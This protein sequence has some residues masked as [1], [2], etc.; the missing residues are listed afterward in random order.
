MNNRHR[1]IKKANRARFLN[2]SRERRCLIRALAG[3]DWNG[4]IKATRRATEALREAAEKIAEVLV[5]ATKR[6][7]EEAAENG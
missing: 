2:I 5:E 4:T 7:S 6:L 3:C 1:Q